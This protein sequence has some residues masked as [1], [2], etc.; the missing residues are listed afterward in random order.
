[1]LIVKQSIIKSSILFKAIENLA[2]EG[3]GPELFP[4]YMVRER[5]FFKSV[6]LGNRGLLRLSLGVNNLKVNQV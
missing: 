4:T 3:I 5:F 2:K 1:M 6:I